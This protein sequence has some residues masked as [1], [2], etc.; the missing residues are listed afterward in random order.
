MKS[1]LWLLLQTRAFVYR[2]VLILFICKCGGVILTYPRSS[3]W[4]YLFSYSVMSERKPIILHKHSFQQ[5]ITFLPKQAKTAERLEISRKLRYSYNNMHFRSKKHILRIKIMPK[6]E[7]FKID[8]RLVILPSRVDRTVFTS[9]RT[10]VKNVKRLSF[11]V[12]PSGKRV[13]FL[14]ALGRSASRVD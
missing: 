9:L 14:S 12:S 6:M 3:V 1:I 11:S 7:K 2:G 10:K 8:N 4:A 5:I 13:D